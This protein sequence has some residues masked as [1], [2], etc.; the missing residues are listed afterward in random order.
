M[1]QQLSHERRALWAAF[2]PVSSLWSE[3]T[4]QRLA[5]R[6]MLQVGEIAHVAAQSPKN[7][8]DV[9]RL[10]SRSVA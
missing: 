9:R 4:Q 7:F 2:L 5:E 3:D 10:A 8:E 6:Y 1:P